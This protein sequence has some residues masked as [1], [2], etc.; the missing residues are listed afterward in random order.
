MLSGVDEDSQS[1][2][3]G[4]AIEGMLVDVCE[5]RGVQVP[6]QG[7][8]LFNSCLVYGWNGGF[9]VGIIENS[10]RV[11]QPLSYLLPL[12]NLLWGEPTDA[13]VHPHLILVVRRPI[14]MALG[15]LNSTLLFAASITN[16]RV[17]IIL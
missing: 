16:R 9:P 10:R 11:L 2:P 17:I 15:S 1:R 12:H 8:F 6:A 4:E 3:I 13:G 5:P 7:F 14:P